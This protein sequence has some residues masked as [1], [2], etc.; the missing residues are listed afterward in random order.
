MLNKPKT[1]QYANE[2]IEYNIVSK[3]VLSIEPVWHDFS[4]LIF[5]YQII[6]KLLL[7][8]IILSLF[9]EEVEVEEVEV[10]EEVLVSF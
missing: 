10:E 3:Q 8:M 6:F 4:Y 5:N 7:K 9:V 2:P 1:T